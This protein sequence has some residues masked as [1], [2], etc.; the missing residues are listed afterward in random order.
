MELL[1]NSEEAVTTRRF[2]EIAENIYGEP[3]DWFFEQWV[4]YTELPQLGLDDIAVSENGNIWH[5]TGRPSQLGDIVFRFPVKLK[6]ETEGQSKSETILSQARDTFF[7]ITVVEKPK[8][9]ILDPDHHI[10]KIQEM[11][12]RNE[13]L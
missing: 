2:R 7:N 5:V 3:L 8:S 1:D 9:I 11:P 12:L 4:D 13:R 10:L 6:I